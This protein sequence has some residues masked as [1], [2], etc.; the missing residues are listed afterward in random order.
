[1]PAKPV[2]RTTFLWIKLYL[3]RKGYVKNTSNGGKWRWLSSGAQ[4]QGS[5]V[6]KYLCTILYMQKI[7]RQRGGGAISTTGKGVGGPSL[8]FERI[9]KLHLFA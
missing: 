2:L 3:S 7:E 4:A 5:K 9:S 8:N 1:V 6:K